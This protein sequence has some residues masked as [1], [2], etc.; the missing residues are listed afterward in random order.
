MFNP[1]RRDGVIDL[2]PS[3]SPPQGCRFIFIGPWMGPP[4]GSGGGERIGSSLAAGVFGPAV[5]LISHCGGLCE[6]GS[7]ELAHSH[8]YVSPLSALFVCGWRVLLCLL[9][10]NL[11]STL[12][13]TLLPSNIPLIITKTTGTKTPFTHRDTLFCSWTSLFHA[14]Q[15]WWRARTENEVEAD[16][17]AQTVVAS[18][19]CLRACAYVLSEM[20]TQ[21]KE[22][23]SRPCDQ[24]SCCDKR[25]CHRLLCDFCSNICCLKCEVFTVLLDTSGTPAHW[26]LCSP[27][28]RLEWSCPV[29]DTR[30][31][32]FLLWHGAIIPEGLKRI[33]CKLWAVKS[34]QGTF[35]PRSK[36]G[37]CCDMMIPWSWIYRLFISDRK[38]EDRWVLPWFHGTITHFPM[39]V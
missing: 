21:K 16:V 30:S 4:A 14:S 19:G 39:C 37:L 31:I 2:L 20:C 27:W 29:N 6:D 22:M 25:D 11:K 32:G 10:S 33:D 9:S 12:S 26:M 35:Y 8:Q 24:L 3:L 15:L 36:N 7:D 38:P 18:I 28:Q 5:P 1:R 17:T 13:S 23:V 34:C